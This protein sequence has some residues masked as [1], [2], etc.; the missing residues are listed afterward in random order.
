MRRVSAARRA[1]SPSHYLCFPNKS[2][3]SLLNCMAVLYTHLYHYREMLGLG[4]IGGP[5]FHNH[6]EQLGPVGIIAV[7]F[8]GRLG[9]GG[10]LRP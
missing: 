6:S 7:S 3:Q 10:I 2:L 5:K 4:Y 8:G 1:F 9:S